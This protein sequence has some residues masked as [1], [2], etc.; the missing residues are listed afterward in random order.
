MKN[1]EQFPFYSSLN[2]DFQAVQNLTIE[3]PRLN[4]RVNIVHAVTINIEKDGSIP[5]SLSRDISVQN[6][7]KIIL[8]FFITRV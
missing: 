1:S 4:F 7:Q 8:I 5:A 3:L 6:H 2:F